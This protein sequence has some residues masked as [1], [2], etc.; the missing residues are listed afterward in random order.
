[1]RTHARGAYVFRGAVP[2]HG[3]GCSIYMSVK[4]E[5][6]YDHDGYAYI[7][8]RLRLLAF[9]TGILLSVSASPCTVRA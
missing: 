7:F 1:M 4:L 9:L 5:M 8:T 6:F 2:E 3:A